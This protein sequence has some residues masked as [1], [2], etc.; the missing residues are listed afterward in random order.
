VLVM[1]PGASRKLTAIVVDEVMDEVEVVVKPLAAHLRRAGVN[2]ASIDGRGHVLLMIDIP[3]LISLYTMTQHRVSASRPR[4]GDNSTQQRVAKILVAD[5]SVYQRHSV[6]QT[7][8]RA[9]YDVSEASDGMDALEQLLKD[10][11]DIFLLDIEMPNL[12]G[13][14]LL[15]I[16]SLYPEL[17]GMKIIM[18][19]SRKSEKHRQRAFA[20]GAYA[21]L[22][23]PCPLDEVHHTIQ[24]ALLA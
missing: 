7:L 18:L 3:E 24:Q 13:Y 17:A 10:T 22:T 2:G 5:D 16:V 9:N 21:Y 19:T 8:T 6:S 12:N 15:N 20:L 14:D 23:K 11:P 4:H 1:M